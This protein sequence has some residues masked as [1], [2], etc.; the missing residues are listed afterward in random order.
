MSMG[1]FKKRLALDTLMRMTLGAALRR[2]PTAALVK[3]AAGITL[4]P[5]ELARL[6]SELHTFELAVWWCLFLDETRSRLDAHEGGRRFSPALAGALADTTPA[7]TPEDLDRL[8]E[9][10]FAYV[11]ALQLVSTDDYERTGPYFQLCQRFVELVAEAPRPHTHR[12][13]EHRIQVFDVAKQSHQA[14]TNALEALRKEYRFD[15]G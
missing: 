13:I 10:V 5:A 7:A 4:Y 2:D 15:V 1:L 3:V 11:D 14:C 12:W 6:S 8:V 9:G